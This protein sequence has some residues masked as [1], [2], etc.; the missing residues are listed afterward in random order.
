MEHIAKA[1]KI[2]TKVEL[3]ELIKRLITFQPVNDK[4][5]TLNSIMSAFRKFYSEFFEFN[6]KNMKEG[7]KKQAIMNEIKKLRINGQQNL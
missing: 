4:F 6:Y 1:Q 7:D 5:M 3:Y 2:K